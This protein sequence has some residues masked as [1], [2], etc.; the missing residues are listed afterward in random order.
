MPKPSLE[1]ASEKQGEI[2]G[3][4]S[5]QRIDGFGLQP[6]GSWGE[7]LPASLAD[8]V[9][10]QTTEPLS[11]T[12]IFGI[13]P[14][15]VS[16]VWQLLVCLKTEWGKQ[17][18]QMTRS[19][20]NHTLHIT[21]DICIDHIQSRPVCF[22]PS[23]RKTLWFGQWHGNYMQV[24]N[25]IWPV[26]LGIFFKS[27]LSLP[28]FLCHGPVCL[29]LFLDEQLGDKLAS[30]SYSIFSLEVLQSLVAL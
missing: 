23:T 7:M 21:R 12:L 26:N 14:V 25:N 13:V 19:S 9:V 15:I 16:M 4:G 11:L 10:L 8:S 29:S 24:Q 1:T 2:P 28:P 20:K 30:F 5:P 3:L 27:S 6:L 18:W 17:L 22:Q